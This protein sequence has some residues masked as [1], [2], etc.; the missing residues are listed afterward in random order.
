MSQTLAGNGRK[1][2]LAYGSNLNKAHMRIRCPSARPVAK[3]YIANARL[4]FRSVADAEISTNPDDRMP[5]GVWSITREDELALDRYEG[6]NSGMYGRFTLKVGDEDA[7]IYMMHDRGVAPPGEGYLAIIRKGYEDFGLDTSYLDA[8][9]AASFDE[10]VLTE[11]IINRR[12]R[13]PSRHGNVVSQ[14]HGHKEK[15]KTHK[16]AKP[17]KAIPAEQRVITAPAYNPWGESRLIK[18]RTV[19]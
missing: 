3:L 14:Q 6:V 8:A 1:L 19:S 7:L 15:A 12:Q 13:N 9:L 18:K 16:K 4:V 10:K 5:V 11:Q 2:Y 17:R